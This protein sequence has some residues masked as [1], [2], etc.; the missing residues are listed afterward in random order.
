M[1]FRAPVYKPVDFI[2]T[3]SGYVNAIEDFT[4]LFTGLAS[5]PGQIIGV[6]TGTTQAA[7]QAQQQQAAAMQAAAEAE[8][9][10]AMRKSNTVLVVGI[11]SVTAVAITGGIIWYKVRQKRKK[12]IS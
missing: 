10:K 5:L 11:V 2:A 4:G 9:L 3:K 1:G 6:A 8:K 12:N 7:I